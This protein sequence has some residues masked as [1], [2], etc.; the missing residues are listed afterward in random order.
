VLFLVSIFSVCKQ[1]KIAETPIEK[2]QK[3]ANKNSSL[4]CEKSQSL[5]KI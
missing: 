1:S 4:E 3:K 2:K 5:Q